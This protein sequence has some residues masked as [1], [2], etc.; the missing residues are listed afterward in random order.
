VQIF[1]PNFAFPFEISTLY[2]SIFTPFLLIGITTL[3]LP[4]PFL[5][6]DAKAAV[7]VTLKYTISS[8]ESAKIF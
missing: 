7:T 6:F 3:D 5:T 4:W 8:L 2:K 1:F